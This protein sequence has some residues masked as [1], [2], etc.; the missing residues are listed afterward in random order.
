ME[1]ILIFIALLF[2]AA[3]I[4]PMFRTGYWLVRIFDFPRG[5]IA[6]GGLIILAFYVFGFNRANTSELLL[7]IALALAVIYQLYKIYPYTFFSRR[8][9]LDSENHDPDRLFS[10]LVSNI[11]RKNR[12]SER[13][14]ELVGIIKPD[15]ICVL[16][17]DDWWESKLSVLNNDY[18]FSNRHVSSDGYGMIFYTKLKAVSSEVN[19]IV[20]DH[21]P[22]IYSVLQL[23]SGDKIAF[24]CVHP[25]PPNPKYSEDTDE[26]DAELLIIGEAVKKSRLPA[27]VAGDLN[28]VAWSHTTHLFQK[29]SGMLDP[30]IGRG[31]YNSFHAKNP[32]IRFPLDHVFVTESF[33]LVELKRLPGIGSDHFPIYVKLSFEPEKKAGQLQEKPRPDED[34]T[35]EA[36]EKILKASM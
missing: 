7:L 9:V 20:E 30:R 35:E 24:Y 14:I 6:A 22:S 13:F 26:R 21:I 10:I 4:L 33:R 16:E 15:I 17:P 12:D 28:D 23:R 31:L 2:I 18:P 19:F 11:Y 36:R 32:A 27:V 3:T 34:D 8:Q 25:D 1:T 29:M 5:Q